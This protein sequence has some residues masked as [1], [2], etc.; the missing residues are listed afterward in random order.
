[1][2]L[3]QKYRK[4]DLELSAAFNSFLEIII[5]L[6]SLIRHLVCQELEMV[7][8]VLIQNHFILKQLF[9]IMPQSIQFLECAVLSLLCLKN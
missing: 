6:L 1:M 5:R 8:S 3:S 7:I 9:T 2:K 4:V